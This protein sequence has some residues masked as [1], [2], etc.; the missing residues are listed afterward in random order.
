MNN[1]DHVSFMPQDVV[2]PSGYNAFYWSCSQNTIKAIVARYI[3][4]EEDGVYVVRIPHD[5]PIR[6]IEQGDLFFFP[7]CTTPAQ[8]PLS[9]RMFLVRTTLVYKGNPFTLTNE[10]SGIYT[11][12]TWETRLGID[13][14][15]SQIAYGVRLF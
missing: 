7:C 14:T 10:C 15:A 11:G 3:W 13:G 9:C 8:A 6:P 5:I 12:K 2:L 4:D 1:K